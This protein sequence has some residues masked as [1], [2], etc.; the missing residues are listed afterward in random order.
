VSL[1]LAVKSCNT[2]NSIVLRDSWR[3]FHAVGPET[4]NALSASFVLF[5][6]QTG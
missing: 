6:G 1:L 2:G 3:E 5:R 4:L